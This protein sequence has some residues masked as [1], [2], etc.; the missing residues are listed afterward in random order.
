MS[1]F[2]RYIRIQAMV[3]VVGIVGPIF[4]TVYFAAQP[5]PT[6]KWMYFTG[7]IITAIEV[8]IALELTRISSPPDTASDRPEVM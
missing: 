1:T 6:L 4:L 5:D 7:L 8:L 2:W 3:F